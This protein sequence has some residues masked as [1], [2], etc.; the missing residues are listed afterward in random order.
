MPVPDDESTVVPTADTQPATPATPANNEPSASAEGTPAA[1][2][3]VSRE[4]AKAGES[5]KKMAE[6]L[7]R[8]AAKDADARTQ[9]RELS[10]DP[11]ERTYLERKFGEQ[12]TSLLEDQAASVDT[13]TG[14]PE[15]DEIK[16]D[17]KAQRTDTLAK[18]KKEL[19]LTLDQGSEFDDLVK[20]LE[21]KNIGGRRVS[22]SDAAEM[23][24]RQLAPDM[25]TVNALIRGDVSKRPED[26]KDGPEANISQ[27]RVDRY[28]HMTGA[29]SAK[30]FDPIVQQI[31][32]TGSYTLPL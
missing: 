16:A 22:F 25:P 12:F 8:L 24:A 4:A 31:A 2:S 26:K 27:S 9:L 19:N 10:K 18:V 15:L 23:A 1:G 29:T 17:R 21:G 7:I 28:A 30:D 13:G 11:Y 14:D 32:K 5:R 20:E 6:G 3:D